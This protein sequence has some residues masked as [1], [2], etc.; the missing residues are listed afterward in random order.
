MNSNLKKTLKDIII[1]RIPQIA[2]ILILLLIATGIETLVP[3]PFKILIDNVLGNELLDTKTFIG[4][5]VNQFSS[6]GSAG[7]FILYPIIQT[8]GQDMF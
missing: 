2:L 8:T 4:H 5:L 7:P 3:W 6:T 1:S